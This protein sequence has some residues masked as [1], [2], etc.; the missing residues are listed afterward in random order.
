MGRSPGEGKGTHTHTQH[1]RIGLQLILSACLSVSSDSLQP[2]GLFQPLA[3]LPSASYTCKFHER[4]D[5]LFWLSAMC[6][7]PALRRP[8]GSV[9]RMNKHVHVSHTQVTRGTMVHPEC[10]ENSSFPNIQH[11]LKS[12]T[13]DSCPVCLTLFT[14]NYT[15]GD[16]SRLAPGA[17]QLPVLQTAVK[18][19]LPRNPSPPGSYLPSGTLPSPVALPPVKKLA[20][21]APR[22]P[23]DREERGGRPAAVYKPNATRGRPGES[24]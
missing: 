9:C 14:S 1:N 21:S 3:C 5:S 20:A 13:S 10:M 2:R 24:V 15:S 7:D 16:D 23:G 6:P 22:L 18:T 11:I 12:Q 19:I 8:S 17:S 4:Q